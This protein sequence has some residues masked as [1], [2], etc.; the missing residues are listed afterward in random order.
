[1]I[2]T[3]S[4]GADGKRLALQP[5]SHK[6]FERDLCGTVGQAPMNSRQSLFDPRSAFGRVLAIF[7]QPSSVQADLGAPKTILSSIQPA[8]VVSSSFSHAHFSFLWQGNHKEIRAG[9][10]VL[11][12]Y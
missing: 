5:T 9:L 8:F 11:F 3:S 1:M 6:Y 7:G 2:S 12:D 4:K 10:I